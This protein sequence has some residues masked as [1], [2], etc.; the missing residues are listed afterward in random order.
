LIASGVL[1]GQADAVAAAFAHHDLRES[2]RRVR[3]EW[4]AI[5]LEPA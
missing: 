5:L 3:C 2:G 1:A 4:A